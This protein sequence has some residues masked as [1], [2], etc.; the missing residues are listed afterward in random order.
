MPDRRAA[1]GVGLE[2]EAHCYDPAAPYRRPSWD[3]ITD[4]VAALPTLPGGSTV[5]V[6]PGG[7]VELSSPPVA[8]CCRRSRR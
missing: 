4:V 8:G 2:I 1:G 6:E 3:E 7:A 5:S